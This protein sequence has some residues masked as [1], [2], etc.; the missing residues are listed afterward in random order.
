MN[1]SLAVRLLHQCSVATLATLSCKHPGFPYA[2][3][4]QY[5]CDPEHRVIFMASALAEHTKNLQTDPRVS[6]CL[7]TPGD[8]GG[9]TAARM[10][11][12]GMA[13]RFEPDAALTERYLRYQPEARDW[14]SL[15]FMFFRIQP[16]RLRVIAGPGQMGWLDAEQWQALPVIPLAEELD[17]LSGAAITLPD[18]VH[19]LGVDAFGID[20]RRYGH[21]RRH[22]WNIPGG[23]LPELQQRLLTTLPSLS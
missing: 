19:L 12:L 3:T 14:Q 17:L 16:H 1:S 4:V 11:L 5:A 15:D 8:G 13:E 20:Y 10:T 9:Q 2:S 22:G 7:I 18:G 21:L 23:D 6:V